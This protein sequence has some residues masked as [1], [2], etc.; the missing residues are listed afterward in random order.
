[1]INWFKKWRRKKRLFIDGD[2]KRFLR[3]FINMGAV[4]KQVESLRRHKDFY[5][6]QRRCHTIRQYG[7]KAPKNNKECDQM[8][9]DLVEWQI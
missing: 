1:M 9:K 5:E 6:C 3:M 8:I 2:Q 7:F 4:I